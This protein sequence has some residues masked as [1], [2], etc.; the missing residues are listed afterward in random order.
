[1][2]IL[3]TIIN[4]IKE[5]VENDEIVITKNSELI[6]D[7]GLDS[8]MLVNLLLNLEDELNL[9]LDYEDMDFDEIITVDDLE[10]Y[11]SNEVSNE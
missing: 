5:I 11:I 2:K 7:I 10:K 8:L 4:G 6:N 3:D 1:M 9:C